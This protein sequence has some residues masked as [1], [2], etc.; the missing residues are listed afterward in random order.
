MIAGG[1]VEGGREGEVD[2]GVVC[3]ELEGEPVLGDPSLSGEGDLGKLTVTG[4][5]GLGLR[6]AVGGDASRRAS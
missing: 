6:F 4:L 3:S 1:T 2:N 5:T